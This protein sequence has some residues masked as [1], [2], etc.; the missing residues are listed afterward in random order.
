MHDTLCHARS[1]HDGWTSR[2]DMAASAAA[3]GSVVT[4]AR[5]MVPIIR[6]CA[7]FVTAPMPNKAPQ[8]T[9][10]VDTGIPNLLAPI[11]TRLV[12]RFAVQPWP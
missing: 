3:V 7:W 8:L 9:W 2:Y 10:V 1:T 11:T 12:T 4:H 5:R 6:Q